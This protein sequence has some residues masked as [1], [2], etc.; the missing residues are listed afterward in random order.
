MAEFDRHVS[1][2]IRDMMRLVDEQR[3]IHRIGMTIPT[4]IDGDPWSPEDRYLYDIGELTPDYGTVGCSCG[5]L[6]DPFIFIHGNEDEVIHE[7]H[8]NEELRVNVYR[9]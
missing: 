3:S 9:A 4:N 1:P 2:A 5:W 8:V 7:G 6:S